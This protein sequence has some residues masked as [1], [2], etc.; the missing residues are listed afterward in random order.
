M[1]HRITLENAW[2]ARAAVRDILYLYYDAV[3]SY[4]GFGHNLEAGSFD[5]LLYLDA[6]VDVP[7]GWA[8]GVDLRLLHEGSAVALLCSLSDFWDDHERVPPKDVHPGGAVW[9][10]LEEGRFDALPVAR[11]AV[12]AAF[13]SQ[14]EFERQLPA[15]YQAYV[16]EHYRQLVRAAPGDGGLP[17]G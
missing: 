1:P 14:E 12:E 8:A 5:P 11:S 15:I 6:V 13:R 2:T 17:L 3:T 7:P 4:G 10:A 9:G 16:M